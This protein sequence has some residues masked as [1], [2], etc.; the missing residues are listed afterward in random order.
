MSGALCVVFFYLA[1]NPQTYN[2]LASEI[3]STFQSVSDI[4]LGLKLD[5]CTYLHTCIEEGLC[6]FAG[7][8]FWRDAE[9]GGAMVLG[10]YIPA[11]LTVGTSPYAL[12]HNTD[13][14]PDPFRYDPERWIPGGKYSAEQVKVAKAACSPFSLGPRSCVA[15]NLAMTTI[16]LTVATVVW[17]MD[18]RVAG[19]EMGRLGEREPHLGHGRHRREEFQL[20]GSFTVH[21]DG[22][23]LQFKK[24]NLG[25]DEKQ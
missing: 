19:G 11:G 14:F 24:R 9:E 6:L 15:K 20:Y 17:S 16:L 21:K 1:R 2:D 7:T 4:G 10:D 12:H 13:Y 23:V 5:S 8:A 18:F 22:P 25:T 3:R